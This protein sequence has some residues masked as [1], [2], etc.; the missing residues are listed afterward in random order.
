MT[1]RAL[2]LAVAGMVLCLGAYLFT[3]NYTVVKKLV[4]V[5]LSGEARANPLLAARML[6]TRMGSRVRESSD[7]GRLD[8]FSVGGAIFL[9][10]DRSDLDS[11]TAARLLAW[12]RKGGHLVVAAERPLSHDALMNMLGVSVQED[13]VR[14]PVWKA[15]DVQLPDGTRLRVE[16]LPSPRLYDDE[17]AASWSHQSYG[18]LRML[19]IPH[20]DGLV[21][22]L[23]TFRPFTNYAIGRLDHA[24][25]LWRLASRDGQPF[26]VWLV[27]HVDVQSLPVWLLHNALPVLIALGAFL[28][29]AL[30]RV[31]PR[32]GP[33]RPSLPPDRRSLVE[34]L[35]ATGRF[36]SLQRRLPALLRIV[37]Q[38]GLDL[39]GARAPETRGQDGAARLKTAA[40]LT[41]RRPR[42][43]LQAFSAPAATP[44]EFTQAVRVLAAFRR[45][46]AL[47]GSAAG[48]PN[49][50]GRRR[51]ARPMGTD[52]RRDHKTR[53][54]FD[55]AFRQAREPKKERA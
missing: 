25:L 37:R 2:Y 55:K 12:V 11:P 38:D 40:R 14:R 21:T 15:D 33:L 10:A 36:Y 30:W 28:A 17:D 29:L 49:R 41:G 20:E 48:T 45:Q 43:L 54:Q 6:L 42:E 22:V 31:S 24:E 19:Q 44:H 47:S 32:F 18:A 51:S 53:A 35:S 5:G 52:R 16:L 50:R 7:L 39:L 8:T 13:E 4:W 34:H 23:S 46:L 1:R 9:A 3:Q 26:E 27:R